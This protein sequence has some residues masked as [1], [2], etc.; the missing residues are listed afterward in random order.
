[1][2][3]EMGA[4]NWF[5]SYLESRCQ[6]TTVA[7][8]TSGSRGV[9]C[10]VPQGSVLGPLLFIIYI[11]GLV[12]CVERGRYYMYADDVAIAVSNKDPEIARLELQGDLDRISVW[13]DRFKLTINADKTKVLWCHGEYNRTDWALYGIWLKGS[14]LSVVTSFNYL[15]VI[16]DSTLSFKEHCNKVISTCNLKLHNLRR[17]CKYMDEP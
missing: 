14:R 8:R 11:N 15:G 10:G 6:V 16:I 7:G 13:C 2:G 4:L 3:C 9:P 1:M 12:K 17:L 5:R